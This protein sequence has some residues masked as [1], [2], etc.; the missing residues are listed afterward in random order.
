MQKFRSN[1]YASFIARKIALKVEPKFGVKQEAGNIEE[2]KCE[3]TANNIIP[4][5][6]RQTFADEKEKLVTEIRMLRKQYS[7]VGYD[8]HKKTKELQVMQSARELTEVKLKTLSGKLA[9]NEHTIA[10]L[11]D[12]KQK[13][14]IEITLINAENAAKTKTISR[15]IRDN[16]QLKARLDQ[17][18]SSNGQVFDN[19]IAENTPSDEYEVERL[20]SH[21]IENRKKYFLVR[22]KGYDSTH[23]SWESAKN[24]TNSTKI[25][26][27]YLKK[28]NLNS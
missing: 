24:L 27:A 7:T 3:P 1:A 11:N 18:H 13:L 16:K 9:A 20:L 17:Y 10:K 6:S 25:L 14:H 5:N 4:V 23:D 19:G 8:L 22:W 2:V 26:N 12:E 15:I 21:K 28:N